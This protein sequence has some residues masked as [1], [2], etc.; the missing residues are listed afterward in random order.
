MSAPLLFSITDNGYCKW[1]FYLDEGVDIIKE[2]L[3]PYI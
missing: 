1:N 2:L 3:H